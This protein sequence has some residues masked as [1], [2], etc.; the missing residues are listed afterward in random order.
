MVKIHRRISGIAAGLLVLSLV[1]AAAGRPAQ[2]RDSIHTRK[3]SGPLSWST[4]HINQPNNQPT[5]EALWQSNIDWVAAN[6]R[7]AGYTMVA[8]D[9]WLDFANIPVNGDGYITT[10]NNWTHSWSYWADYLAQRNMQLGIYYNPVW[11][12]PRAYN[13]NNIVNGTTSV[14]VR[15]LVAP[16]RMPSQQDS[17]QLD[18][19]KPGAK[20]WVQNYV[21][22]FISL[23]A[24]YLRVDFLR[25]YENR[26]GSANYEAVLRWIHEAA[27]DALLISLVMPNCN[28]DCAVELKYGDMLRVTEDTIEGGWNALSARNRSSFGQ[29]VRNRWPQFD[30]AWDGFSYF[31]KISGKSKMILDGDFVLLG[32]FAN[33][34]ERK[35]A[36]SLFTIAG[37]PIAMADYCSGTACS[38]AIPAGSPTTFYRNAELIDAHN[39]GLVGKPL[40]G[41]NQRW[42]GQ[43]SDGSLIVALFNRED[44]TQTRSI[45]YAADLGLSGSFATRDLWAHTDLGAR[46]SYS[47]TLAPHDHR[48]LKLSGS[49]IPSQW[50]PPATGALTQIEAE[51]NSQQWNLCQEVTADTGSGL[52]VGCADNNDY[53]AFERIDFGTGVASVSARV[54]TNTSGGTIEYRLDSPTGPLIGSMSVGNTGGWQ[55]WTTRTAT[56]SGASG[57]RTLYVVFKGSVAGIANLNWL[58]F[59]GGSTT[60]PGT[61]LFF[62]DFEDGN[63]NGWTSTGGSW[64]VCQIGSNSRELC[65]TDTGSGLSLAGESGWSNYSVESYVN[66]ASNGGSIALLGRAQDANRF[67]QLELKQS[68]T[69][70]VWAIWKNNNGAWSQIAEGPFS[71]TADSYYLLRFTLTGSTLTGE[72]STN[73]GGSFQPLGSGSDTTFA[74]GKIGVRATSSAARWD[75]IK[76]IAR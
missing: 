70:K 47:V 31:A 18:P 57:V 56:V 14:R 26:W 55:S 40:K 61:Q 64:S 66:L 34:T 67:Y 12:T 68:G 20:E 32:S 42:A 25:D 16:D 8:T 50:Q 1:L 38:G 33:D 3:G 73:F 4:Y 51:R 52:N 7:D 75:Q 9:G 59:S 65:K 41:D 48:I 76:V 63:A 44:T 60:P 35:T 45:S 72:Y 58:R 15:D 21:R 43:T 11:I 53:L 36:I 10:Y 62:D 39:K 54:A 74:S 2:A 23:N 49:G 13:Q 22:Y 71:W 46:S 19:T 27:G 29:P 69:S 30:N 5:P 28:N 37:S 17:Y 6:F 24:T